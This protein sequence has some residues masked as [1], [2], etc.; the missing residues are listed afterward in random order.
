MRKSFLF[1]A[2]SSEK[3]PEHRNVSYFYDELHA[4]GL[5]YTPEEVVDYQRVLRFQR[6]LDLVDTEPDELFYNTHKRMRRLTP[7][8]S[9]IF[10]SCQLGGQPFECLHKFQDSLTSDG[11]CCTFNMHGK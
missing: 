1:F 2:C 11:F 5:Y 10:V 7:N 3:D 4:F 8:C 9:D 6:F